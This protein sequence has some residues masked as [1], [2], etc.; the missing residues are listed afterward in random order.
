MKSNFHK[1]LCTVYV[2][3]TIPFFSYIKIKTCFEKFSYPF[4]CDHLTSV[5]STKNIFHFKLSFSSKNTNNILK[6]F[7]GNISDQEQHL[8]VAKCYVNIKLSYKI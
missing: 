4:L 2:T 5:S 6:L 8:P 1:I 3:Y 7:T